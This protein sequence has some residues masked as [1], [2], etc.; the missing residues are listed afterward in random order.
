M[1]DKSDKK[2]LVVEDDKGFL[3]ILKEGLTVA[4]FLVVCAEDGEEAVKKVQEEKPDLIFLD[5]MLPK[6]DG[7]TVAKTLKE[8]GVDA[9]IIF[10]TNLKDVDH[11]S[12]AMDIYKNTDYIIKSDLHLDQIIARVKE[13]LG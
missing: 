6:M 1:Q 2:I 12:Q 7:I 5:I 11:I 3:W 8:K 13:K 9:K 10:L 4:G